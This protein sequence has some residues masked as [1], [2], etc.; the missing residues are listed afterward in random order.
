MSLFLRRPFVCCNLSLCPTSARFAPV[1][2]W[3]SLDS[4]TCLGGVLQAF[5]K[6]CCA[7]VVLRV[8][9][10]SLWESRPVIMPWKLQAFICFFLALKV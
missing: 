8:F 4:D 2:R 5:A 3:S 10:A 6:P 7:S 9:V 1:W